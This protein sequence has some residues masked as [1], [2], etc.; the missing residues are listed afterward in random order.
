MTEYLAIGNDEIEKAPQ[1][2][3]FILCCSCGKRHRISYGDE[4]LA[5]GTKK[6]ST[7][8]AFYKCKGKLYL[9][10]INGKGIRR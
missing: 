3:D 1:L 9:A 7:L 2:G 8:L 6:P 10:G 4:I 5:D